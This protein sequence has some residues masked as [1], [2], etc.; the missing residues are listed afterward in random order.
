M[1]SKAIFLDRDGTLIEDRGFICDFSQV[2]IFPFAVEAVRMMKKSNF[3]VI[4]VTNQSA[5]ARG[6]C[7]ESQVREIHRQL[8]N[9]FL[10][11]GAVI[12][13]FYYSPYHEDGIVDKYKKQ[14]ESRK[15]APGMILQAAEN[16]NLD[17]D[18]SF[19][20]GDSE[21]DILAGMN[22]GC[23]SIL[24]LTGKGEQVKKEIKEKKIKPYLITP[25]ILTAAE[26]IIPET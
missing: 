9:F 10:D 17:L 7:S 14:H 18:Q 21:C 5:I 8:K 11:R 22:A 4:V 13:D 12:D 16:Y 1:H 24:V 26:Y 23:K 2:A 15:P 3:K 6:I 19:L 20:I 25:N